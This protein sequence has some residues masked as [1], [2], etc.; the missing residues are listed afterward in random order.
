[1]T[2]NDSLL[3]QGAACG[4]EG[5]PPPPLLLSLLESSNNILCVSHVSPD[6]DAVGSLLGLGSI[7]RSLGKRPALALQDEAM[8]EFQFMPG[9]EEIIGPAEVAHSYDLIVCLDTSSID[10][11]G[12]VYR[13]EIHNQVPLVV[14][15]HHITNTLFGTENWVDTGCAATCQM[16]IHLADALNVPL[17]EEI[18][19][20]LL[21]GLVTDTLCFRTANTNMNVLQ[22]SLRL[23][24]AGASLDYVV[25]NTLDS[26]SFSLVKLWGAGLANVQM[27]DGIIW[28]TL[29]AE[30]RQRSG[31]ELHQSDGLANFLVTV[32]EA[33]ISATFAQRFAK[34]GQELIECSFRAKPGF[35]VSQVAFA[36]GGGG[37]PPAAGC[38]VAGTLQEVS[39]RV[40]AALHELRRQSIDGDRG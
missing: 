35:N 33:D 34:N 18:A 36:F 2:L 5:V 31:V 14:I 39:A 17:S 32:R 25:R 37:H 3:K 22:A 9:V 40:V 29:N 6:G 12:T 30:S 1:M 38:T 8:P 24:N 26:R 20:S 13:P 27:D 7:L 28:A 21:T 10:R 15:D 16:L 11:M 19:V 23:L 4:Q